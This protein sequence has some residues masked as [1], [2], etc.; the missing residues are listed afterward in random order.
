MSRQ[1][2]SAQEGNFGAKSL[3][4]HFLPQYHSD[5]HQN[6]SG[7]TDAACKFAIVYRI[8]FQMLIGKRF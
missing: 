6:L 2:G 3:S 1:P 5:H 4:G 7:G 8:G